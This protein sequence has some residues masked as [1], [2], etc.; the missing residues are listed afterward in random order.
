MY[1][2]KTTVTIPLTQ[3]DIKIPPPQLVK[4]QEQKIQEEVQQKYGEFEENDGYIPLLDINGNMLYVPPVEA[5]QY[6]PISGPKILG[7]DEI[8]HPHIP[9]AKP[10]IQLPDKPF[11][12][13]PRTQN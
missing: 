1:N 8:Y 12:D 5:I 11:E 7:P 2:S 3:S 9:P 4:P 10:P 6:Q 13:K